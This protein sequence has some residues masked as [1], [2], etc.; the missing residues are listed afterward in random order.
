MGLDAFRRECHELARSLIARSR[1]DEVD[2]LAA[3]A[4][5]VAMRERGY[6]KKQPNLIGI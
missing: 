3:L 4:L 2:E 5:D 6:A 1:A